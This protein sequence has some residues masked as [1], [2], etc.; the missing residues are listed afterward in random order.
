MR[1]SGALVRE[2]GTTN[3]TR[4][5][6]Y[7]AAISDRTALILRVHRSNFRIEGF[8]ERPPLDELVALG[9]RFEL[10]VVENLGSGNLL[11]AQTLGHVDEPPVA[12]QCRRRC[13]G[14]LLQR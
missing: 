12:A 9:R 8:T 14:L 2:V 3:K 11:D 1:Q 6:D 13:D 10:P 5:A 7:A 4:T